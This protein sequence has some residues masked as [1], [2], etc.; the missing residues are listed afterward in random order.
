MGKNLIKTHNDDHPF[1]NQNDDRIKM[2]KTQYSFNE[3]TIENHT[4]KRLYGQSIK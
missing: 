2:K 3:I 4:K 1:Q